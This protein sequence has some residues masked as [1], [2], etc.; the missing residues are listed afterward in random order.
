MRLAGTNRNL[1]TLCL[2]HC[3]NIMLLQ[4]SC[5]KLPMQQSMCPAMVDWILMT[6]ARQ[7][8]ECI[9]SKQESTW[10]CMGVGK[11]HKTMTMFWDHTLNH[12]PR[13]LANSLH[14][15]GLTSQCLWTSTCQ[16]THVC[17]WNLCLHCACAWMRSMTEHRMCVT[18]MQ[19]HPGP[20]LGGSAREDIMYEVQSR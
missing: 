16:L 17:V 3:V 14:C 13:V 6:L 10:A 1:K 18:H 2:S 19:R 7:R 20:V 8:V 5:D 9:A 15:L 12:H 11:Y 4:G